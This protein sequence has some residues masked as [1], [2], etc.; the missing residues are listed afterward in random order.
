MKPAPPMRKGMAI[1]RAVHRTC[2]NIR[3]KNSST[4]GLA[5]FDSMLIAASAWIVMYERMVIDPAAMK[6]ARDAA[7]H[8]MNP[9]IMK[10][11]LPC[12]TAQTTVASSPFYRSAFRGLS[13]R[14][15]TA[16]SLALT[17]RNGSD[18]NCLPIR[19]V[20]IASAPLI[21]VGMNASVI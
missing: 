7:A 2:S 16:S 3:W 8:T 19:A 14:S 20:M 12:S 9:L 11:V 6:S 10:N 1:V 13:G 18:T 21:N 17:L 5:K 4:C 15:L